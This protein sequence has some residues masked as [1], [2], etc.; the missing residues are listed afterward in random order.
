ML[1]SNPPAPPLVPTASLPLGRLET[2]EARPLSRGPP[3]DIRRLSGGPP[4]AARPGPF[5]PESTAAAAASSKT[6]VSYCN[7]VCSDG[8]HN[9]T[10]VQQ[11][12]VKIP[13]DMLFPMVEDEYSIKQTAE[14]DMA[15]YR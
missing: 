5:S 11:F 12:D 4:P 6:E 2:A 14:K 3:A 8:V 10:Y 7:T 9:L 15:R 13:E 1:S